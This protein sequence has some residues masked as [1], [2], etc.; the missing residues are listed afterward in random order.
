M[1]SRDYYEK[2]R[3]NEG[4]EYE[5]DRHR[6]NESGD[7]YGG[8]RHQSGYQNSGHYQHSQQS[9]F[10]SYGARPGGNDYGAAFDSR[11]ESRHRQGYGGQRQGPA[12]WE[13]QQEG[14]DFGS[15]SR[16]TGGHYPRDPFYDDEGQYGLY[17]RQLGGGEQWGGQGYPR[18]TSRLSGGGVSQDSSVLRR[19]GFEPDY[20]QWREEQLRNLDNDY[21]TWRGERYKKFSEDFNT[22]RSS[23][24]R[25]SGGVKGQATGG[26]SAGSKTKDQTS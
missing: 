20:H 3:D 2:P 5:N 8:S 15:G 4:R 11:S 13:R 26:T 25:D 14:F 23:R 18:D 12:P 1:A 17:G 22:W 24:E 10:N 7:G 19:Q 9:D 6:H 21:E 16:Q